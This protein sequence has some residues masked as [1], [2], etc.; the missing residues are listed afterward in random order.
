MGD[1]KAQIR[2]AVE[3]VKICLKETGATLKDV[4]NARYYTT[5]IDGYLKL[6]SWRCEQ[7]PDLFGST[8]SSQEGPPATL[9]GVTKLGYDGGMVEI[10]V[11][12]H[13]E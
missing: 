5:D 11:V 10:E 6:A 4:V 3:N 1:M 13:V 9:V 8:A 7:F 2:Q 12:A